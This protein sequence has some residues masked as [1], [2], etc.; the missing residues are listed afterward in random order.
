ML[1]NISGSGD[2]LVSFHSRENQNNKPELVVTTN[3]LITEARPTP[4]SQQSIAKTATN[5]FSSDPAF[6][7]YPN[8]VSNSFTIKYSPAL[9]NRRM[10]ITAISGSLLKEVILTESGTQTIRVDNLKEGLYFV[11]IYHNNQ[12]YSQKILISR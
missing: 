1:K 4:V 8:P 12:K 2:N 10:Q 9:G 5:S 3:S 7:I 11:S 6:S